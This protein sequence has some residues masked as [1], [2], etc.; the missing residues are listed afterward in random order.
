MIRPPLPL[1]VLAPI[2]GCNPGFVAPEP[3]RVLDSVP[4]VDCGAIA[5]GGQQVC[6]VPLES[7]GSG[8]ITIFAIASADIRYPDGGIG[9]EGTAFIVRDE[10]WMQAACGDGDCRTLHAADDASDADTLALEITFAPMVEGNYQGELTIWSDDNQTTA[11][12]PLQH[13]PDRSEP[14]W[15]VQLRGLA[16]PACGRVWPTFLDMGRHPVPGTEIRSNARIENCGI[17]PLKVTAFPDSGPGSDTLD[18]T[19]APPMSILPGGSEDISITWRVGPLTGGAPTPMTVDVGFVSNAPE[20]LGASTL[21]VIGNACDLSVD[22]RWDADLDG[23]SWCGGDCDDNEAL[24]NPSSAEVAGNGR[25]DDCDG[26]IDETANPVGSDDDGDGFSELDGDCD[27]LVAAI[28]PLALE[29]VNQVD[30]D[31]ND[32]ID[33]ATDRYDDD[34]DGYSERQ[35]DCDDTNRL[36]SPAVAETTDGIDN[37]CDGVVDEGGPTHDDDGDGTAEVEADRAQDDC[38][39]H[40]YWVYVGAFEHCDGYDNDCDGAVD[41]GAADE[42]DGACAFLPGRQG[43]PPV[44]DA[45]G[46]GIPAPT[47]GGRRALIGW[48]IAVASL[49]LVRRRG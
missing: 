25:D 18:I 21:A 30:D 13:A 39:D 27:D 17:V 36:V 29:I 16:R 43:D 41:E 6:T 7:R 46:C 9:D 1:L 45:T 48:V 20:T 23:W 10:Y 24:I 19:T 40:D 2:L 26:T 28:S 37:D 4:Y 34:L 3:T 44:S 15:K 31:C 33:D 8:D 35:G 5:P 12:H 14:I 49:R 47:H 42:P 38:D 32:R 11:E 22:D